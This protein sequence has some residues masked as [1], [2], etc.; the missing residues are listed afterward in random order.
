[1]TRHQIFSLPEG[2]PEGKRRAALDLMVRKAFP[3]KN[4]QFAAAWKGNQASVY[5]WDGTMVHEAQIAAGAPRQIAVVP[6][7]FIRAQGADGARLCRMLD[8]VEGQYW[9]GGFLQASR[10]WPATPNAGEW[11]RFLRAIGATPDA[12]ETEPG[13]IDAPVL[14]R[15]WTEGTFSFEDW[16]SLLQSRR[17]MAV[18]AAAAVCPF[19]FLGGQIAVLSITERGL[20]AE[21]AELDKAN[22]SIRADRA[23]AY[24]NLDAIEELSRLDEYPAQV[25]ILSTAMTLL[26]NTGAPRVLSWSYDRGNLELVLRGNQDLDPTAFITLFERDSHFENASGT[27]IGQDRDLQLRMNVV[28]TAQ[29]EAGP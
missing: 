21:R 27:L 8:G 9:N 24:E 26:T 12:G 20:Q 14:E 10:W 19:V 29:S 11:L 2:L 23:K 17:A 6:E 7:T 18:A 3:Y 13:V 16:S 5:A 22:R 1:M 4:P 15:P 25:Q 28:K